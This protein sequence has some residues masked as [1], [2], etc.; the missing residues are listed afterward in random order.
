MTLASTE[1]CILSASDPAWDEAL[2]RVPHDL[3]HTALYHRAPALGV[4]G[5]PE[6]FL[7]QENDQTFLWPY[8]RVPIPAA[9]GY[10]DVNSAY[11]YPGPVGR[12]QQPFFQRAWRAILD[13]WSQTG[14]VSVFTR[15]N[16]LLQNVS[17]LDGVTDSS[18]QPAS[19][20]IRELGLTVSVDLTLNPDEQL[21][22]Y[23]KRLRQ[24]IR[25]L[26][27]QGFAVSEDTDFHYLPDFVR[28]YNQTM[29]RLMSRPE[30]R[31]E[32]EW[33][34][35]FRAALGPHV[36][37]LVCHHGGRLAAADLVLVYGSFVHSHFTGTCDEF[38]HHSPSKL[39]LDFTRVWGTEIGARSMHLGGGLGAR[40]DS[41]FES[42]SRYSPLTH[43]F[44]IGAWTL[45]PAVDAEL[46]AAHAAH[47]TALGVDPATVTF[48]PFYRYQPE[49]IH[50]LSP[51]SLEEFPNSP[52]ATT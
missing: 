36:R 32:P 30:Y 28:M 6:A 42:K 33:F 21:R 4:S 23:Q 37:L 49:A 29:A 51:A 16:P 15:F 48:F 12:G 10:F 41:L 27:D 13:H 26:Y 46:S 31:L 35:K 18:G 5:I 7:F 17:L 2:T 3:F 11:G 20:S 34:E 8:Y 39:L 45:N 47:L 43:P 40:Q 14:V 44:H 24:T 38:V 25:K 19:S 22:R 1:I 9:P 50:S 52:A